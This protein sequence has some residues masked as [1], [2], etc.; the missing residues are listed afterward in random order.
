MLLC[1]TV[2]VLLLLFLGRCLL[3]IISQLTALLT[4]KL[5]L[6]VAHTL[7][8]DSESHRTQDHIL[9]FEG[10]ESLQNSSPLSLTLSL[11]RAHYIAWTRTA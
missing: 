1:P 8:L 7:I 2:E 6:T 10:S 3:A 11:I 9:L 4:A 5:L